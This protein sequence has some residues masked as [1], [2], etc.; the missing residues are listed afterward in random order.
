MI[1][2]LNSSFVVAQLVVKNDTIQFCIRTKKEDLKI[3]D[4]FNL[5]I[6]VIN[7]SNRPIQ[8]YETLVE[9]S[10]GDKMANCHIEIYKLNEQEFNKFYSRY[11]HYDESVYTSESFRHYDIGKKQLPVASKKVIYINLLNLTETFPPGQYK[12][13]IHFRVNTIPNLKYYSKKDYELGLMQPTDEIE[14]LSTQWQLFTV[15]KFISK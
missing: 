10:R 15:A 2:L 7:I 12:F 3:R 5:K 14:Y 11:I 4:D 8:V 9:G 1:I 13:R 6:E